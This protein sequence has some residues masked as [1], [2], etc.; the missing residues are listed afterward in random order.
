MNLK[1][2]KKS[3]SKASTVNVLGDLMANLITVMEIM[4]FLSLVIKNNN[5]TYIQRRTTMSYFQ[6]FS[7]FDTQNCKPAEALHQFR[8]IPQAIEVKDDGLYLQTT[9]KEHWSR[10]G[11]IIQENL[12]LDGEMAVEAKVKPL[13]NLDGMIELWLLGDNGKKVSVR[14]RS[15]YYGAEKEVIA[16]VG[17]DG[18]H[19]YSKSLF[20]FGE[21]YYVQI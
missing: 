19:S 1:S 18:K 11:I 17:Y 16:S 7:K 21:W 20:N 8:D 15:G 10:W 12:Q 6:D 9:G 3:K 14:L 5:K 4:A 13:G 2:E